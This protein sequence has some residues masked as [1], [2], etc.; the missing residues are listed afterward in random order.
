M[1]QNSEF[2]CPDCGG[3]ME[4]VLYTEEEMDYSQGRP[5]P[6]GR[7]RINVDYLLCECCGHKEAVD[8][9]TFA[10]GWC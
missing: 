7:K 2:R 3:R 4:K 9:D 8:G 10:G 5:R 1:Y 6:T